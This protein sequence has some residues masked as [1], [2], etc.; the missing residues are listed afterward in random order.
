MKVAVRMKFVTLPSGER[1]TAFGMGTWYMGENPATRADEM[2]AL[3]L[4]L[5]LGARLIDTAEMYG[6]G[7]AEQLIGETIAGRRDEVFL[8]SKVY[9]HNA[10][11]SGAA[12]ACERSLRRLRTDRIDLY[13]LHWRGAV[14]LAETLDAFMALQQAGK[15]RYYGVSN[16]DVADMEELWTLPGGQDVQTDQVLY[17]LARRGI[18]WDLLPWLREHGN[19]VMAYSPIERKALAEDPRL[20]AFARRYGMTP[21]QVAIAWLLRSDDIIVIPKASNRQ[22]LVENIQALDFRLTREQLAELDEMFPPPGGPKPLE[23]H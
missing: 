1:V 5:D 9:P 20:T 13:L 16:L 8:V 6:E 15:I 22:H 7:L 3:R 4:G 21:A 17:N 18:E 12:A 19:P 11:R 2:A 10:T 23:M 14:P